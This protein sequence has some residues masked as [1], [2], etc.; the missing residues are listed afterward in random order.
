MVVVEDERNVEFFANRKQII[1]VEADLVV[2]E[3]DTV[4]HVL[5]QSLEVGS[6]ASHCSIFVPIGPAA[7]DDHDAVLV[8]THSI[9]HLAVVSQIAD[10][11]LDDLLARRAELC[12]LPD[13]SVSINLD[14]ALLAYPGCL[15][16]LSK[17][18]S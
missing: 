9:Q 17:Q 5:G 18:G 2:L 12:K 13:E 4:L 6:E 10:G 3:H 16:I 7:V 15:Q 11:I 14:S 8:E 1:D